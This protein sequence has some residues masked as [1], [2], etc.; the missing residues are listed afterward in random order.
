MST[1]SVATSN[2]SLRCYYRVAVL[3]IALTALLC[4]FW[5]ASRYPQLLSKSRHVGDDVAT[6]AYGKAA[7]VV[8]ATAPWWQKIIYGSLNWLDS[9]K[10]GMSFGVACGAVLHTILKYYPL[11]IGDNLYLNSLK[12]ALIGAPMGVC[13]NCAVPIACGVTRGNGRVEVALGFLFSSPNFNPI[14]I[15]MSVT[16]LP[17]PMVLAKYAVLLLVIVFVVP[18]LVSFLERRKPFRQLVV[19]DSG[20]ACQVPLDR[21]TC[22]DRLGAVCFELGMEFLRNVWM[23]LKPTIVIM[24][25]MSVVSATL[26]EF[27]PWER[28]LANPTPG[29]LFVTSLL[30]TFM[31][32]PIGLDVMFAAVLLKKGIA[33]E[34]V[35]LFAMTLGT[36]SIV[37]SIFLWREVS[38]RLSVSLFMFFVLAGWGLSL[39]F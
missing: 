16:A 15:M 17:M 1:I 24:L 28:L 25:L 2:R 29:T 11:K 19:K 18:G 27:I 13:A 31:P 8:E 14:V 9:M 33:H 12:G 32:I 7:F 10:I 21:N 4:L 6:M 37:P 30:A 39:L 36:F 5:F 23:L 26:L 22:N 38:K 20:G 34:F 3:A 35:M